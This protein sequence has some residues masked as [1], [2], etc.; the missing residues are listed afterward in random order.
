MALAEVRK[1]MSLTQEELAGML[2]IKQ[3]AVARLENRT[4]MYIS[5]PRKYIG[6][7]GGELDIVVRF[8]DGNIHIQKLQDL[9]L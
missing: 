3:A 1:A 6:A 5:S 4:D 7:L 2:H 9:H 8:P